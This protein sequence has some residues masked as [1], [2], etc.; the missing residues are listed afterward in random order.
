MKFPPVCGSAGSRVSL[1]FLF[2]QVRKLISDFAIILAILI[3]CGVDMLVGV[4][5][6]KLLVPSEFKVSSLLH[7]EKLKSILDM[8]GFMKPEATINSC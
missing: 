1:C 6:P 8:Y 3:F 4:D 2:I 5:T 7:P